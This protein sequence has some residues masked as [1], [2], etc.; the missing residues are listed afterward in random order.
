[1]KLHGTAKIN[2]L[3]HLE[4]G[5]CDMVDI[6]EE[7]GTPLYVMDE[8]LIRDNCMGYINSFSKIYDDFRVAYAGKA[9]LN[10]AMCKLVEDEGF[11]LDVVSGGELYTAI[12]ANFPPEKIIFHG[13]N[14]TEDEHKMALK[15]GVGRIVVDNFNELYKL[16]DV[17]KSYN[18]TVDIYLRISPGI[19]AHTHEYIKTGQI[20]S[21]FGFPIYSGQAYEAVKIAL[22]LENLNLIGL[23]CHIGSQIFE[24]QPYKDAAKV[25]VELIAEIKKRWGHEIN[26]L[27][28]GG[29]FGIYYTEKDKPMS[30]DDIASAIV[31]GVIEHSKKEGV[32]LPAIIV[33]PGRSI[34]GNAGTT[35]YKIGAIK[36]IPGVRKYISVD[37]GM[38]DNIRPAL[39]KA[40]YEAAISDRM[41]DS[42][43]EV[44]TVAGKCCESGD[45]LIKDIKMPKVKENDILAIF[46]TGAY[47]ES[48]ASNYN[49]IPRPAVVL[50]YNGKSYVISKRETY[51]EIIQNDVIP[52]RLC[53]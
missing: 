42:K 28:M 44:V 10:I 18:K 48:M 14:K 27:D 11:Y 16:N 12:K 37:G 43:N 5:G 21:K 9:F 17:A 52:N 47:G 50:V 23:H 38:V 41:L 45:I 1:M 39:Y 26:E 40:K 29:G 22:S 6:V 46:S 4:I 13:N 51:E 34:V 53:I 19:E 36:D 24:K 49:R 25:M 2:S 20:D 15:Y 7:Y 3:N 33:E 8:K 31:G 30:T 32:K 35:L